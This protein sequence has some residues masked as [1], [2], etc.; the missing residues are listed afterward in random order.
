MDIIVR[1][2]EIDR[3]LFMGLLIQT[4][5]LKWLT[6]I[7]LAALGITSLLRLSLNAVPKTTRAIVGIV[8][9]LL[10]GEALLFFP[11]LR[12]QSPGIYL[13]LAICFAMYLSYQVYSLGLGRIFEYQPSS[14][15][16]PNG[17]KP[18]ALTE[19]ERRKIRSDLDFAFSALKRSIDKKLPSDSLKARLAETRE[20]A[21]KASIPYTVDPYYG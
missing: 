6:V 13:M 11:D 7:L 12:S 17:N 3:A 10:I 9:F 2:L 16:V 21:K 14:P 8:G 19:F 4:D 1:N 15:P 20:K 5:L 18:A